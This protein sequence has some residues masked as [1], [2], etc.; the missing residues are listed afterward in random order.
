MR[1]ANARPLVGIHALVFVSGWSQ[2]EATRGVRLCR[3]TGYDFIE[4]PLLDPTS[5]D[6]ASTSALLDETGLEATCSLGLS[7][8]TDTSAVDLEVATRGERL[9]E[10]ALEVAHG[11]GAHYLGGVIYSAM[12][13]YM[14]PATV[15]GRRAAREILKRIAARA[16]ALD[17]RVGVEPVN[18]YESNLLNTSS[19]AIEFI[20]DVGSPNLVVHL[21]TYHMNIEEEP[22]SA[23]RA[24]A[25]YLG[26]VHVGESNRGYLGRGTIDFEAIFDALVAIKY[27]GPIAF[28]SFSTAVISQDFASALA[29]W[30]EPWTDGTDVA[31]HAREFI[32]ARL[33]SRITSDAGSES[34]GKK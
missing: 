28:E 4:I 3:E 27:A 20:Q 11:L 8:D 25:D 30:R 24:A 32:R 5:V 33:E 2:E 34:H 17:V 22:A 10:Q 12:G 1:S 7:F 14:E 21:D 15:A 29:V 9:L 23:I 31:R 26:Y 16:E 13:K 19:Q 18:R 6:V